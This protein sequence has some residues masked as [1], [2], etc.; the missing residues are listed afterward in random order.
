[1]QEEQQNDVSLCHI[2][3]SHA[4]KGMQEKLQHDIIYATLEKSYIIRYARKGIC[5]G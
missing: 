1:M 5:H 3:K 2:N 4:S